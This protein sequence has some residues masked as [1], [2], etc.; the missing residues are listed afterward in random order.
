M[1]VELTAS[2]AQTVTSGANVLFTDTPV[3]CN[4]GYVV[5]REGAGIATLRGICTGCSRFARYRV[6]YYGN[7]SIPDGGTAEAISIALSLGGEALPSTTATVT[8]A[9]V[10]NAFNVATAAFIDVPA[11]CCTSLAVKN[12]STQ[13]ITVENSNLI[14][15]RVA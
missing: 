10:E 7:I 13:S 3:A 4:R 12:I 8:P 6:A 9:A 1:A 2:A 11:G 5:H 14:I 15:E